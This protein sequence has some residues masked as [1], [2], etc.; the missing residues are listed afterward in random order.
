MQRDLIIRVVSM[1]GDVSQSSNIESP[2]LS[3]QIANDR[4]QLSVERDNFRL[5]C[6][7]INRKHLVAA[8]GCPEFRSNR[9]CMRAH[10]V[11]DSQRLCG[12]PGEDLN[13]FLGREQWGFV[14]S[15]IICHNNST[16]LCRT[17]GHPERSRQNL[18]LRWE[19]VSG[20]A[21]VEAVFGWRTAT[22]VA[23]LIGEYV[24]VGRWFR[25]KPPAGPRRKD[26]LTSL[27]LS[28]CRVSTWQRGLYPASGLRLYEYPLFLSHLHREK[29]A[30][31]AR[32]ISTEDR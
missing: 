24:E 5:P 16:I 22:S 1:N 23:I 27:P 2:H 31:L 20:L 4:F 13:A 28:F 9:I 6:C 19:P 8:N 14:R 29:T 32:E 11:A 18:L 12:G 30:S 3:I 10:L 26:P 21:H 17:K 25:P 15:P 7:W